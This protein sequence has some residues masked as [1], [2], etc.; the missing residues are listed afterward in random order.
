MVMDKINS[1]IFD[2]KI[3]FHGESML[4]YIDVQIVEEDFACY[5]LGKLNFDYWDLLKYYNLLCFR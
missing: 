4:D 1:W 2:L 3:S 5:R